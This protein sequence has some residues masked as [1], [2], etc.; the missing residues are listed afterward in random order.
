MGKFTTRVDICQAAAMKVGAQD[1]TSVENP[2][3]VTESRLSF[4]Y[5]QTKRYVLRE[6]IWNF[7]QKIV[8]LPSLSE[9]VPEGFSK[10]FAL[11]NDN[12]RFMGI[13]VNGEY[14]VP[15]TDLYMLA[16]NKIY[17]KNFY[18]VGDTLTLKYIRDI[19]DVRKFDDLFIASFVLRLAYE[20]AFAETQ[21]SA[22]TNRLLEEYAA[23][24]IQAKM[25]DGQEQKPR[26]VSRS[27]WLAARRSIESTGI[28]L[29]WRI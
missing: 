23:S 24:I 2:K 12:V 25:V 7:A 14:V 10:V 6:G 19:N 22:L 13:I 26:R 15:D 21:K 27:G 4:L 29:P 20:L 9:E 8:T 17:F 28:A 3:T 18:Y 5:D 16:D 11:P 1:I